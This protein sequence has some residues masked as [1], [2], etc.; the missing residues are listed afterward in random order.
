MSQTKNIKTKHKQTVK[1]GY[2][3]HLEKKVCSST[4]LQEKEDK[5]EILLKKKKKKK[6]QTTV[7]AKTAKRRKN[8]TA[9]YIILIKKNFN[10]KIIYM[11]FRTFIHYHTL[12]C[13]IGAKRRR[14]MEKLT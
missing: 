3:Y 7:H 12:V 6:R 5:R 13:C 10:I 8:H 1:A 11:S 9:V 4:A 14:A 2:P